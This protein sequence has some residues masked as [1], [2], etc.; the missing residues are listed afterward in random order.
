[1]REYTAFRLFQIEEGELG[2]RG[3]LRN[4]SYF[5]R[6][7]R[8]VYGPHHPYEQMK[9]FIL[10]PRLPRSNHHIFPDG[11]VCYQSGGDWCPDWTVFS[12]YLTVIRFLDDF[13]SG[14]MD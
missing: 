11:S 14:R 3:G 5:H 1:M 9:V 2:W 6:E 13:Y 7:V 4:A 10:E 12:V 8:L